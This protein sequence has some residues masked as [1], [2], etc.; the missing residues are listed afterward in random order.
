MVCGLGLIVLVGVL[1]IS[2]VVHVTCRDK[3]NGEGDE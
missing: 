2:V 3:E 1:E